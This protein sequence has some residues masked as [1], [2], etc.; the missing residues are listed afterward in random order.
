MTL[1]AATAIAAP[2]AGADAAARFAQGEHCMDLA[3][4]DPQAALKLAAQQQTAPQP[5]LAL[6]LRICAG[7]AHERAGRSEQALAAY[8][9]AVTEARS[10]S[11]QRHLALALT[12]RGEQN[13]VRG[14]YTSAIADLKEAYT[15]EHE[16]GTHAREV[17]VLNAIANLYA[18]RNVRDYDN[19]LQYYR[20]TLEAHEQRGDLQGQATAHFNIG[21]TLESQEKL[22]EALKTMQ[23]AVELD[24]KR[25]APLDVADDE[26]A[27]A[28]VLSKLGRHNDALRMLADVERLYAKGAAPDS[29]A[30]FRLS[31]GIALKRAGRYAQALPD[32]DAARAYFLAQEN[33]R[34]LEKIHDERAQVLAALGDW[35]EAFTARGEYEKVHQKLQDQLLDERTARLRVQF[36]SEQQKRQNE[37]LERENAAAQRELQYAAS[38]RNWQLAALVLSLAGIA[39]LAVLMTRQVKL[40]RT[41]RDLALTDELTRLP[42]RRHFLALAEAALSDAKRHGTPMTLAGLDI[43]FFK[44]VN[45]TYGHAAG[46]VLLQRVAH[47][48]RGAVRP[49]DAVGR[50]G[51]EEFSALLR[52]ADLE[53]AR[54]VAE[55]MRAAVQSLDCSDI[56]PDLRPTISIGLS[57]IVD[58]SERLDALCKRADDAL[59]RA[60][61]LGRNCV[62]G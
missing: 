54:T 7:Y 32:I 46:D 11:L 45:D 28:V 4:N 55:R 1:A 20:K 35:R 34:F 12:L 19:A 40:A 18:D 26:K 8:E 21:S 56:S 38:V 51:G 48:L 3:A 42:N 43:D 47:A 25:G 53:Q 2:D 60:K 27:V 5:D 24:R 37:L 62:V 22:D 36:D 16:H 31:R 61:E 59:Y 44:K 13:A 6:H 33:L 30:A 52:G 57:Q 58:T 10:R 23:R 15:L 14:L 49:S 39:A 29:I 50:M 9:A 17:Y 41:M